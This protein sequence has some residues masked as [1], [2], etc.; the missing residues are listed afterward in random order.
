MRKLFSKLGAAMTVFGLAAHS[1]NAEEA[2]GDASSP[3]ALAMLVLSDSKLPTSADVAAYI[4][5]HWPNM[6]SLKADDGGSDDLSFETEEGYIV[7]AGLI[8][9]PIP[10]NELDFPCATNT[11]WKGA[12]DAV[13]KMR[14]HVIITTLP[15]D[16]QPIKS[17]LYNTM[18]VQAVSALSNSVG[19]YW[20]EGSNFWSPEQFADSALA[21]SFDEPPY[22]LWVG[23]KM[24]RE[25]DGSV[26]FYTIGMPRFGTRDVEVQHTRADIQVAFETMSYVSQYLV[27]QGPVINDGDTIGRS[28][29][30]KIKVT[31]GP[32]VYDPTKEVYRLGL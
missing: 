5:Q 21:A 31:F 3:V 15:T 8:D 10:E 22:W 24:G 30:E 6:P 23:H 11:A 2:K 4:G 19:V 28:A 9:A 27:R 18:M 7:Y 25:E 20:G 17:H 14:A 1:A 32:S 26:S 12:C 13:G 29:E 16:K